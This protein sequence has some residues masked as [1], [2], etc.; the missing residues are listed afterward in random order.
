MFRLVEWYIIFSALLPTFKIK[1]FYLL[2][3]RERGRVGEQE[4]EKHW[5][6]RETSIDCLSYTHNPGMR[7]DQKSNRLPFGLRDA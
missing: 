7:S 6:E 3:C 2:I 1:R 4:G 5:C